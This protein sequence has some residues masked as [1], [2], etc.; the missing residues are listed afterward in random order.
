MKKTAKV[1]SD[2]GAVDVELRQ[3]DGPGCPACIQEAFLVGWLRLEPLG[4][5]IAAFGRPPDPKDFC[6]LACL[7]KAVGLTSGN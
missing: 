2:W 3:C 1:P 7:A 5:E 4:H 6:S